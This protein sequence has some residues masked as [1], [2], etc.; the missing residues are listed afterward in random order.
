V[1]PLGAAA[2]GGAAPF[3]RKPVPPKPEGKRSGDEKP[4]GNKPEGKRAPA[5]WNAETQMLEFAEADE[6]GVYAVEGADGKDAAL[7]A[8]NLE[9]YESNLTY[10][11]ELL[12]DRPGAGGRREAVE[13]GLRERL[14]AGE[15]TPVRFVDDPGQLSEGGG[16]DDGRLWVW[17]LLIVLAVAVAEPTLANRISAALIARPRAAPVAQA[18]SSR[19]PPARGP[20][21]AAGVGA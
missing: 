5:R 14:A 7:F 20:L 15:G 18:G 21:P 17:V 6:A 10:L 9:N 8:V 12:A 11:D 19:H 3:V 13:A 4:A 2:P 16:W 1:V